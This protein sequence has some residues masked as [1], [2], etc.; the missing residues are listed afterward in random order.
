MH[1][2]WRAAGKVVLGGLMTLVLFGAVAVL[3]A[4]LGHRAGMPSAPPAATDT[5]TAPDTATG[6]A[7][8][9][10]ARSA[11]DADDTPAEEPPAAADDLE[12]PAAT[13]AEV[14]AARF[15]ATAPQ[16]PFPMAMLIPGLQP[17]DDS[18]DPDALSGMA[19]EPQWPGA[20]TVPPAPATAPADLEQR[21]DQPGA[22]PPRRSSA[23]SPYV[24]NDAMILSIKRRLRLTADQE[25]LWLPVEA[26]LRKLVYSRAALNP[27]HGQGP[28][29]FIDPASSEDL[30]TAALPLIVHL[31]EGQKREVRDIAHVMGLTA[32]ASQL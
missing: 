27:Q 7:A 15:P 29:P 13:A 2:L 21:P 12:I 31:N 10:A 18:F 8:G 17:D 19:V 11:R 22:A 6:T 4:I 32:V 5:T 30:K 20:D 23:R 28:V 26:A 9:D 24:L 1:R 14:L 3:G 25:K 16:R